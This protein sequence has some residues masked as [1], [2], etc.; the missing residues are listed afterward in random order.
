MR[1]SE[2]VCEQVGGRARG[3]ERGEKISGKR[4]RKDEVSVTSV[5]GKRKGEVSETEIE[6]ES[7]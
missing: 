3:G 7:V 6:G 1:G 2:G 4:L 5:S